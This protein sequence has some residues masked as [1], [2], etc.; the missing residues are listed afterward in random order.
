MD[1]AEGAQQ[2]QGEGDAEAG[3]Q[4]S[5]MAFPFPQHPDVLYTV[6]HEYACA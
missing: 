3:Q 5:F 2:Q 4:G 6:Q 1:E